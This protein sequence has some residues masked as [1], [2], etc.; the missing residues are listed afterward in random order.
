MAQ[1]G[2]QFRIFCIDRV[3]VQ[4]SDCVVQRIPVTRAANHKFRQSNRSG[5]PSIDVDF[6]ASVVK[7]IINL[8]KTHNPDENNYEEWFFTDKSAADLAEFLPVALYFGQE[9]LA[10][11]IASRIADVIRGKDP[12]FV[13]HRLGIANDLTEYEE[14]SLMEEMKGLCLK[15]KKPM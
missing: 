1:H 10:S 11:Q 15:D 7:E 13:R 3:Q 9:E 4:V 2:D 8:I 14:E 12:E 5:R 6:H